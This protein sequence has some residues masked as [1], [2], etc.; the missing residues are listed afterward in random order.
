MA[1]PNWLSDPSFMDNSGD[2]FLNSIFDQ[3]QGQATSQ[4]QQLQQQAPEASQQQQSQP[5]PPQPQP[6]PQSQQQPR[7]Q[8]HQTQQFQQQPQ[9]HFFQQQTQSPSTMQFPGPGSQS[10]TPQMRSGNMTQQVPAQNFPTQQQIPQQFSGSQD[11][12]SMYQRQASQQMNQNKQ[13]MLLKMKQQIHRQKMQAQAQAQAQAQSQGPAQIQTSPQNPTPTQYSL[14]TDLSRHVS[15]HGS[16]VPTPGPMQG[17]PAM[18]NMSNNA[19]FQAF[20]HQSQQ[21]TPR[22]P[23]QNVP[24]QSQQFPMAQNQAFQQQATPLQQQPQQQQQR[25]QQKAS[26]ST[27]I[28][29]ET[30][31]ALLSDFMNRR[32]TP[33][34]QPIFINNKRVSLFMFFL[35]CSKLGGHQQLKRFVNIDFQQQQRNPWALIGMKMGLYAGA[36]LQEPG[37]KESL[38]REVCACYTTYILPYEE[39]YAT[40]AGQRDLSQRKT[41]FQSQIIQKY[42]QQ[43]QQQQQQFSQ[44]S[45]QTQP[46]FTPSFSPN[47]VGGPTPVMG[48]GTQQSPKASNAPTP[49]QR[50]MSRTSNLSNNNSPQVNSPYVQNQQFKQQQPPQGQQTTPQFGSQHNTPQVHSKPTPQ[51]PQQPLP[52]QQQPSQQQFPKQFSPAQQSQGSQLA[53]AQFPG[54]QQQQ[55]QQIQSQQQRQKQQQ[56]RQYQ[57]QQQQQLS[58]QQQQQQ[59][60]PPSTPF[61]AGQQSFGQQSRHPS[62]QQQQQP[63]QSATRQ[64]SQPSTA[65]ATST[66]TAAAAAA[67]NIK[68]EI[69]KEEANVLRN[70]VP[71]KRIIDTHGN[72]HMKELSMLSGEIEATKPIYL[73]APELGTINLQALCMA[74][75]SDQGIQSSEVVNALNTLLVTTSDA[76]YTFAINDCIELLDSL[77]KLGKEVLHK[78]VHGS[79]SKRDVVEEDVTKLNTHST[80]DDVFNKY[81]GG[82]AKGEDISYVVNSLTGELMCEEDEDEDQIN[83]LF[84]FVEGDN[85]GSPQ[86]TQSSPPPPSSSSSSS[87]SVSDEPKEFHI[88][89]YSTALQNFKF[90]NRNHFSKLQTKS[91]TNDQVFLIDELI[92]ITMILRNIS[93]SEFN[94]EVLANNGL[95]RGLLFSIVKNIAM[96]RDKFMFSRKRLCLLK[97]CLLMLDNISYFVQLQSLEEAFLAYVLITSFGP[98]IK[99]V[100]TIPRCNLDTHSYFSFAIDAFTKLLVREP[101]N[102]SLL[103][104]IMTGSLNLGMTTSYVNSFVVSQQDHE[105]TK[106][107]INLYLGEGAK[108]LKHGVLLTRAFQSLMSIIPFDAN[109][110]EFSKFIFLRAPTISQMLFGVKLI[111]DMA[112][113]ND[114]QTLSD[115]VTLYWILYNRELILGNFVRIVVALASETG[116]FPK[117]SPEHSILSSCL[118]KAL[119]TVNS[120]VENAVVA[121]NIEY[122]GETGYR[123]ADLMNE[124][125]DCYAFPRIIP[126]INLTLDTFLAPTIDNGL[127]KEIV[128]LLRYL[129]DLKA[130]EGI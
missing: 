36:N 108:D 86:S 72:H 4:G 74:I 75:K 47:V 40:P 29:S 49:Q 69:S 43:L 105:H 20:P 117:E 62:F 84:D 21:Q 114:L 115:K 58:Q 37:V 96:H 59:Q 97:D 110:F 24:Q 45:P 8:P 120:L 109:S 93:F 82:G 61:P 87:S 26:I 22:M 54:Q 42:Q 128:R 67:A 126:D 41:Q 118:T 11:L 98:K 39:Y 28:S 35:L 90:E 100:W 51:F 3:N 27:Q 18:G 104:A 102:R 127:G 33:I 44:Q 122:S 13:E 30:F 111:I 79:S 17:T 9:A 60:Q 119:I 99:Q 23:Q 80:I 14:Q 112:P 65:T 81:V 48:V 2:D 15:P 76:N 32:G 64:P 77:C 107:L 66:A 78:V 50:K 34:P 7:P 10:N 6:Q 101:Y 1:D 53:G 12:N 57:L 52:Q 106:K 124:L 125:T 113:I 46:Q 56:Q 68:K 5:P 19:N 89:D 95:F 130:C 129:K 88:D 38:D 92:T 73:F 123:N 83:T 121:R 85:A 103:H 94:K 63:P 31:H 25:M 70:Y 71:F 16:Q 91:A 116:K 55:Q